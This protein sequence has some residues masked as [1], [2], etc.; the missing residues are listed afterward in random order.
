MSNIEENISNIKDKVT[1]ALPTPN[2]QQIP[3]ST[4]EAL[5]EH[6]EWGEPA[7]SIIDVRD[8][9]VFNKEHITGAESIPMSESFRALAYRFADGRQ[10]VEAPQQK[11][12]SQA[13]KDL[14]DSMVET[15]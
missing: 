7:L 1:G 5:K 11:L 13:T 9:N 6:L 15:F 10:F 14:I 8:R 3:V 4:V 12:I 2:A